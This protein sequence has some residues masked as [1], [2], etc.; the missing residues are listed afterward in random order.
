MDMHPELGASSGPEFNTVQHLHKLL[1]A[2][3]F[4]ITDAGF[5]HT[6]TGFDYMFTLVPEGRVLITSDPGDGSLIVNLHIEYVTH[7]V[8]EYLRN[9]L[10]TTVPREVRVLEG[11]LPSPVSGPDDAN[12][13][14]SG[15]T[16]NG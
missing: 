7:E 12:A 6:G 11:A 1:T 5:P 15:R 14:C 10:S 3:G 2:A 8:A 9:H 13:T 4:K 16:V